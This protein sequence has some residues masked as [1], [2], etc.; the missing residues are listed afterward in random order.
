VRDLLGSIPVVL[1]NDANAAALATAQAALTAATAAR[2]EAEATLAKLPGDYPNWVATLE[3]SQVHIRNVEAL[4]VL[5]DR[6]IAEIKAQL[7]DKDQSL[8]NYTHGLAGL[9]QA[10]HYSKLLGEKEAVIQVLHRA[11]VVRAAHLSAIGS[12]F[13]YPS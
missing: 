7:A 13:V 1:E 8:A 9:E 10:K 5:R 4:V 12:H 3:A 2:T 11:C 6:E